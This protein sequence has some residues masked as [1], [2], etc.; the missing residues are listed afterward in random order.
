MDADRSVG[1]DN[2]MIAWSPAKSAWVFLGFGVLTYLVII[3][4]VL[5]GS[6][7]LTALLGL[8]TAGFTIQIFNSVSGYQ[9]NIEELVPQLGKNVLVTLVTPFLVFIGIMVDIA[10]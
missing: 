4:G 3:I 10:L 9:G 2:F 8:L 6:L 7:P 1:R 5:V